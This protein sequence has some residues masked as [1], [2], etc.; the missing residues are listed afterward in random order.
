MKLLM[1]LQEIKPKSK[2]TNG[3]D[4]IENSVEIPVFFDD[5]RT[6]SLKDDTYQYSEPIS[7]YM[8][9]IPNRR[10][11]SLKSENNKGDIKAIYETSKESK[12]ENVSRINNKYDKKKDTQFLENITPETQEMLNY[13]GKSKQNIHNRRQFKNKNRNVNQ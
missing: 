9:K 2:S 10:F 11:V 4:E 3:Y 13:L 5:R 1:I 6:G 7:E 8:D 12:K